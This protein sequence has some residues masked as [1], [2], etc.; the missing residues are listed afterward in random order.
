MRCFIRGF[1][2]RKEGG[3]GAGGEGDEC[4][5]E[6]FGGVGGCWLRTFGL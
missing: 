2:I 5:G 4:G 3:A 1:L 6:G